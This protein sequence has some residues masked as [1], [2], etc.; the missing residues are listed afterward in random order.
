M[1]KLPPPFIDVQAHRCSWDWSWLEQRTLPQPQHN[2][3][4]N[5]KQ[6][7]IPQ[8]AE[9]VNRLRLWLSCAGDRKETEGR[10][11]TQKNLPAS[12]PPC[13]G[14]SSPL[15]EEFKSYGEL[16]AIITLRPSPAPDYSD[17]TSHNNCINTTDLNLYSSI[18]DDW[19]LIKNEKTQIK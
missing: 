19:N 8:R 6:Q 15:L 11:L 12:G 18:Q 16:T 14:N 13:L 3:V 4:Q 10:V 9:S 5:D 17:S 2:P 7:F 1:K